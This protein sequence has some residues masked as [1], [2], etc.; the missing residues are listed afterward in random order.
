[1]NI[2]L[3]Y[4]TF[5]RDNSLPAANLFYEQHKTRPTDLKFDELIFCALFLSSIF[6]LARSQN[7]RLISIVFF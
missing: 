5:R 4:R 1:M 2:N 3:Q 7:V 6:F